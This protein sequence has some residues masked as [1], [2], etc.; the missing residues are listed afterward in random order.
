M[1]INHFTGSVDV[2]VP[3]KVWSKCADF[4]LKAQISDSTWRQPDW[5]QSLKLCRCDRSASVA[6]VN[7]SVG[8]VKAPLDTDEWL[9]KNIWKQL[10]VCFFLKAAFVFIPVEW[11]TRGDSR[12]RFWTDRAARD[13]FASFRS[14][15][16][17]RRR[18]SPTRCALLREAFCASLQKHRRK[19]LKKTTKRM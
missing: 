3:D 11:Q 10:F 19:C 14:A 2:P 12:T 6:A 16:G 8:G 18:Q 7:P 4:L 9:F 5:V 15:R 1:R 13:E 17:G